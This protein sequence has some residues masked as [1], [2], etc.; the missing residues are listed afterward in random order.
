MH[1]TQSLRKSIPWRV[2]IC[3]VERSGP[4]RTVSSFANGGNALDEAGQQPLRSL[5]KT[6]FKSHYTQV[7]AYLEQLTVAQQ[8]VRP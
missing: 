2:G 7:S 4:A 8:K 5:L 6:I 3:L 1:S